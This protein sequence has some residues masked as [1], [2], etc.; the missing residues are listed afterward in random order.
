MLA[1]LEACSLRT[2]ITFSLIVL[3]VA[4]QLRRWDSVKPKLFLLCVFSGSAS[5]GVIS[6]LVPP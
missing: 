5:S 1:P 2:I 6:I 4:V 3:Y